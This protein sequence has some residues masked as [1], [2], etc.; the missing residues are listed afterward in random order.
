MPWTVTQEKE[1]WDYK[2][3]QSNI[4]FIEQILLC[5]HHSKFGGLFFKSFWTFQTQ[6]E[7]AQPEMGLGSDSI[8]NVLA[9]EWLSSKL[10]YISFRLILAYSN[11]ND[12]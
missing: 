10:D 11:G 12:A 2:Q 4:Q 7:E 6:L 8:S 5:L 3:K 9:I 1:K